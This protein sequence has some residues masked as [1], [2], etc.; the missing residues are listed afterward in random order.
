MGQ[1]HAYVLAVVHNEVYNNK[2][3]RLNHNI[4]TYL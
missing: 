2:Q 3:L 4:C 1:L